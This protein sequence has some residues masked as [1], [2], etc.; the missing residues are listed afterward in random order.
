[1]KDSHFSGYATKAGLRCADG[2]VITPQAFKDMDGK[3]VPLV[4]QH[5]HGNPENVLGHAVL[6]ARPDGVYAYGYFNETKS[7]KNARD[8][9]IHKD[10]KSL[11]IYANELVQKSKQVLHGVINEVS[12]VL[13]GANPGAFIENV[14]VVH[15]D[16]FDET[17]EDEAVIYTG[18]DLEFQ[19]SAD[20]LE[21]EYD[22]VEEDFDDDDDYDYEEDDIQH[23]AEDMTV[24][25][26]YDS[27]S[28]QQKDV[29][30]YMI[31]AA[32]EE[33]ANKNSDSV[34]Q[35][36]THDDEGDLAHQEGT[37]NM[38]NVFEDNGNYQ[39]SSVDQ[40]E[41]SHDAMKGILERADKLGSLK[42]ATEEYALE[43][44]ITN[45]E[46]LFPDAKTIGQ[47]PEW[48]K[49]RTEWVADVLNT[50]NHAPFARVRTRSADITH[51]EARAKGYI[52]GE[53]KEE[54]FF[55]ISQR[56]TTPTTVY[57][58]QQ[59]DRDDIIDITDFDVVTWMKGEMRLMLEEE[60]AR[61]V[62]VGDGRA[63]SSTDK[64]KDPIGAAEGSGIRSILNDHELFATT[65]NV[66]LDDADSDYNEVFDAVI[67]AR[68]FFR[69]SG[70]PTFYTT[71]AHIAEMMLVKDGFKRR[72][73]RS[74]DEL[75]TALMVKN[76]VEVEVM[77]AHEDLIGIIVDLSDYT[78]G[79][80]KGGEISMF[81]D[82]DIDVNKHKYLIETR[83][84]GALTKVKSALVVK[85]V[86][87]ADVLVVPAPPTFD[88]EDVTIVDTTGVTY[89]DASDDSEVDN[90]NSPYAV[91]SGETME[92]YAEADT[93][94]Y[95]ATNAEDQWSFTNSA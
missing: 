13:R 50:T 49:R 47:T 22:F 92:V 12:L 68:R 23:A 30:H 18:L 72:L 93:S 24:Q 90:T 85:K 34:K 58:K 79:A 89:Y 73:Y 67:R 69:G 91:A 31:G 75:A 35:S 2:R 46:V 87:A 4:W 62:L 39:G 1:M 84:S 41:L 19:H 21:D 81:D 94:Y 10:I 28:K 95:F 88:G 38:S 43:H 7:G 42:E 5:G 25:D 27:L 51:D 11:S 57:K 26:V 63:I 37:Q 20:D 53:V 54:E 55:G 56:T 8:L 83:T 60:I 15:G 82:F 65:V 33:A 6:E 16:G 52:K 14:T 76:V 71:A 66:N 74:M 32:L 29:V 86:A 61:A 78:L 36:A 77:E 59:L 3:T 70:K 80:D 9:V 40:H 44:G 17:L 48:D 45:I 64:V